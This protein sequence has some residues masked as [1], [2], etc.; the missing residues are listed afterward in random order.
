MPPKNTPNAKHH[1]INETRSPIQRLTAHNAFSIF[2]E[3]N[4]HFC[5]INI[6][7][8]SMR[9]LLKTGI[10]SNSYFSHCISLHVHY[11]CIINSQGTLPMYLYTYSHLNI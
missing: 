4:T 1:T 9:T 7:Y 3:S 10:I 5:D 8:N 2:L 11:D 6:H